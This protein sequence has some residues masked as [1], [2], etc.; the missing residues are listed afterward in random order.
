MADSP[1]TIADRLEKAALAAEDAAGEYEKRDE[2]SGS[3]DV[4]EG[5]RWGELS[6]GM[7]E[8][9]KMIE[10]AMYEARELQ[11]AYASELGGGG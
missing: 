2:A 11:E 3:R 5:L 6:A 1:G 9:V 8:L 10:E 4:T 7:D